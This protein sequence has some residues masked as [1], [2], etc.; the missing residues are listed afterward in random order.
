[1][2]IDALKRKQNPDGGWPYVGGRSCTEPTVYAILALLG[3]DEQEPVKRAV[4]WLLA[5]Q[6]P[7]GGWAPQ[8]GVDESTWVTALVALLPP[9]W[10]GVQPHARAIDWLLSTT[11]EESTGV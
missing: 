3:A 1:M 11:G 5:T 4:H 10:L 9:G 8:Q 6:R 2:S 7:D